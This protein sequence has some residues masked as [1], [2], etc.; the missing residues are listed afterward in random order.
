GPSVP[1]EV[2]FHSGDLQL[3]LEEQPAAE[4]REI[5]RRRRLRR[6]AGA[7]RALF[8]A[9]EIVH[10]HAEVI[11]AVAF[12]IGIRRLP[13]ALPADDREVDVAVGEVDLARE[14]AVAAR[15]LFEA[16]GVLEELRGR[17]GVFGGD[18]NVADPVH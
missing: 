8:R 16:E 1:G 14:L 4:L 13:G 9:V 11:Q 2:E 6:R 15:E 10:L 18:R 12:W 7:A 3:L 5:D 17:E